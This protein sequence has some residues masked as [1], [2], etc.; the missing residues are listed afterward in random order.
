MNSG[1][2]QGRASES[3]DKEK[4]RSYSDV[5]ES[6]VRVGSGLSDATKIMSSTRMKRSLNLT[7][8]VHSTSPL[9]VQLDVFLVLLFKL[10]S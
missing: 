7:R 3:E 2:Q 4:I 9:S 6:I 8:R 1:D 10:L 5:K